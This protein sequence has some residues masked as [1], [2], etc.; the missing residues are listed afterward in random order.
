MPLTTDI[1][2]PFAPQP[3]SFKEGAVEGLSAGYRFWEMGHLADV[4]AGQVFSW[5]RGIPTVGPSSWLL[6]SRAH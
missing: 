4:V 1:C 2:N 6:C 3:D 5:V